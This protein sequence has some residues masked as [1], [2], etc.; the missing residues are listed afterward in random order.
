MTCPICGRRIITGRE[1]CAKGVCPSLP[2]PPAPSSA[3]CPACGRQTKE[4]GECAVCQQERVQRAAPDMFDALWSL[5]C[6]YGSVDGRNGNSGE[7][8]DKA[9]AAI[10]K[11]RGP[12]PGADR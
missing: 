12:N 4:S 11:A 6:A 1:A 5:M 9:R 10:A 2:S 8:W 7:C 3:P